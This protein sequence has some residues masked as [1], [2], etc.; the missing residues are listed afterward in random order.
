MDFI[1]DGRR[2]SSSVNPADAVELAERIA[3]AALRRRFSAYAVRIAKGEDCLT[4]VT[5]V[6]PAGTIEVYY[7]ADG[8]TVTGIASRDDRSSDV[9]G[10]RAGGSLVAALGGNVAQCDNGLELTCTSKMKGLSYAVEEDEKCRID[11]A[12]EG[13]TARIPDCARIGGF[14][15]FR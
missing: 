9:L 13:G 11:V 6:G 7:D 5:L 12:P 8:R 10:H 14:Q 3:P 15:I 1:F 2:V 4:C